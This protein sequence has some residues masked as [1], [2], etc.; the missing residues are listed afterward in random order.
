MPRLS[1]TE[2][3]VGFMPR[4][5]IEPRQNVNLKAQNWGKLDRS[6]S[7]FLLPRAFLCSSSL[8]LYC[9][10]HCHCCIT[11]PL[12]SSSLLWEEGGHRCTLKSPLVSVFFF[13]AFFDLWMSCSCS[14]IVRIS[15]N[16]RIYFFFLL[17]WL[18][19]C[20][21][22]G[23]LLV[24]IKFGSFC[25]HSYR[26]CCIDIQVLLH[27]LGLCSFSKCLGLHSLLLLVF[28]GLKFLLLS[29]K[30]MDEWVYNY[31]LYVWQLINYIDLL[32]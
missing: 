8:R 14:L 19:L 27:W 20:L 28:H 31:F 5:L 1:W 16:V 23:A 11:R 3:E 4:F 17:F 13:F 21:P 25:C 24:L 10:C 32:I 7:H 6:S 29:S 22:F 12:L 15:V 30:F 26:Y 9:C 2:A 18:S